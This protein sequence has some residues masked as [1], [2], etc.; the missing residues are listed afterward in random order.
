MLGLA[1][2]Y[3]LYWTA[4]FLLFFVPETL[5]GFWLGQPLH[6]V[7]ISYLQ[8]MAMVQPQAVF[9]AHWEALIFAMFFSMLIIGLRADQFLTG[10]LAIVFLGQAALLPFLSLA[11]TSSS[12][13]LTTACAVAAAFGL[14][15]L[16]LHRILRLTGGLE[17]LERLALLSL[18]AVMPQDTL[19]LG[20][21]FIYPFF[22]VR[23]LLL[24]IIPLYL[25][26]MVAAVI[27]SR[28]SAPVFRGGVP[29][30]EIVASSAAAGLLIV[31]ISLSNGTLSGA[32]PTPSN[33]DR[34]RASVKSLKLPLSLAGDA[35]GML[36]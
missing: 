7:S 25:A 32:N 35:F 8:A 13:S 4:Q 29:W 5:L 16:G 12:Q 1:S 36:T 20:I 31:A 22:D 24:R 15:V 18:L 23:F 19:W 9:P 10:A 14:I 26:A 6:V 30:T 34:H 2:A 11:L 27:H 28:S 3:P 17:F 33:I 21:K